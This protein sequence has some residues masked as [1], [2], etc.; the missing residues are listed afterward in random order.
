MDSN[1]TPQLS[2]EAVLQ[3]LNEVK[4][5]LRRAK[6]QLEAVQEFNTQFEVLRE[7]LTNPQSGVSANVDSIS[8]ANE[9]I[10]GIKSLVEQTLN[11][12]QNSKQQVENLLSQANNFISRLQD[13]VKQ[14]ESNATTTQNIN[15]DVTALKEKIDNLKK[16]SEEKATTINQKYEEILGNLDEM[17]KAYTS[18]REIKSKI[19][20]PNDGLEAILNLSRKLKDDIAQTRTSADDSYKQSKALEEKVK[21]IKNQSDKAINSIESNQK[22]SEEYKKQIG[23][24]L[25]VVTDTSV[26]D[27]FNQR[28][29]EITQGLGFWLY[30]F[31]ITIILLIVAISALVWM[32]YDKN[33][34][35]IDQWRFWYRFSLTSPL[36]YAVYFFSRN[37]SRE[38]DLLERYAFKFSL[39]LSLR[40][41]VQLLADNF[42]SEETAKNAQN[43]T[44]KTLDIVYKEPYLEKNKKYAFGINKI[45]N[46]GI[47]ENDVKEIED[48]ILDTLNERIKEDNK[49]S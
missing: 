4:N 31:A 44:L 7:K 36:I 6:K 26:G 42:K 30:G 24:I 45:F 8:Q 27:S 28:K 14:G 11:D 35:H 43:F 41:Y 1:D 38:R 33:G 5:L 2:K 10:Q 48:K 37:Y 18:F 25:E 22:E 39:S 19:E 12:S 13:L 16:T 46:I 3:E 49:K 17:Q 32:A 29:K 34:L 21:E 40:S 9:K 15:T 23:G 47:E 20:D